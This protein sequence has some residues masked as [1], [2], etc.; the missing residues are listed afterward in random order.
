MT[1]P[2]ELPPKYDPS[3][4]EDR[5]YAE[6]V[7][8][9]YFRS[10]PNPDKPKYCIVIPP[11]NVTGALH[12]GHALNNTIQDILIRWKRMAGYEALWLPGTDHAGIATQNVVEKEL[13]KEG[14]TRYDVGREAFVERVWKWKERFGNRII[15]QLK[16]LGSSCD[17]ERE[18]FTLDE[19]LSRAVNTVF[20]SLYREGLIYR[21]NYLIN[22]CP[23]CHTALSDD[24]VE[25]KERPGK[26]WYLRYPLADG[27]GW[28]VV[29]TT[30]PETM[31]GD[32]A[33]AVNPSDERYRHLVG[34]KVRLPFVEREIPIIADESVD[35][36][37]GTGCVKITPAHDH[38]DY[39]V[40]KRH[41]LLMVNVLDADATVNANGG[42][43][44]GMDRYE[45]RKALVE[46]MKEMGL[47]EREEDYDLSL[48]V[49]YRCDTAVEPRLSDQ[50]FV[51]MKE[52]AEPAIR[53]AKEGRVRFRPDRWVKV[54]LDWLEN[55]RDWCISR[56]IWWGHPIPVWYCGDCG[57]VNVEESEPKHCEEC[58]GSNLRRDPDVL[59]TWFSSALWPFSTLGWPERTE[60]LEYYYPTDTLVT[61]RGIIYFWVARMVMM[62][63]KFMGR[64]PFS[65]VV[66][67]GTILDEI[68]R[69]MSKSLGNGID[70]LEMI[71][72]YGADALRFS[73][74]MLTTEGQDVK[75]SPK[76]FEMG[77]NFTNKIWN[78]ARFALMRMPEGLDTSRPVREESLAVCDRWILT[79]LAETVEKVTAEQEEFRLNP[80]VAALYSFFWNDLCDWYLEAIKA[81][82]HG[83][84]GEER[85]ETAA[86]VF[87]FVL[88]S[89]LRLL[90]PYMP[91]LTE[92]LW[93]RLNDLY[94]TR[95]LDGKGRAA[96]SIMVAP[97]PVAADHPR[98][99]ADAED[100]ELVKKAVTAVRNLRGARKI[101]H[102]TPLS[103][104]FDAG[105]QEARE[106]LEREADLV[107]RLANLKEMR[108]DVGV[109]PPAR[110]AAEIVEPIVLFVPMGELVDVEK[111]KARLLAQ[112]EKQRKLIAAAERKLGNADFLSK[113]PAHVVEREREK[114]AA[115][116]ETERKMEKELEAL[117]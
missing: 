87:L 38:N 66:I 43:F 96:E 84:R 15:E 65:D 103:A 20:V 70:P 7:R 113:A 111:E 6:W 116:R 13:A 35:P 73:L 93:Q 17:W 45:C 34:R 117:S 100:M 28:V 55:V 2:R 26:L 71:A 86:R 62:G 81:D 44:E 1:R 14:K 88:D 98:Y 49:C 5:I 8:K 76:K 12:M 16:K 68:G 27:D 99:P 41:D 78:A 91:F 53:A 30:R 63:L 42:P 56:Q 106:V 90:H 4:V 48:S 64:E 21:G 23:R 31:L 40:G 89:A 82:L 107:V 50:W 72:L 60:D 39:V 54:Y 61:D 24:E 59:D 58:G 115:L 9:G 75:L 46:R 32:T 74:V 11:P 77:R 52:L 92:E 47:L 97:W 94:P 36:S 3:A 85:K 22:W 83:E 109:E 80:A 105:S 95:S 69:R 67:H 101:L 114:L 112:L 79:R 10:R 25:H 108:V 37:F 102:K 110:S 51:R 29:A 57:H 33:V 104:L 18:R 19:G